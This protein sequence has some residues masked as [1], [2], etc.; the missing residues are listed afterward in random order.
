MK[1]ILKISF[2]RK[3]L[4]YLGIFIAIVIALNYFILPWYVNSPETHVP[5]VLGMLETQAVK[6]LQDN[7]FNPMISDTTFN[8]KYPVG[9]VIL[10]KP[11]PDKVVKVGRRVYL[12]ISGGE[13]VIKV[14]VLI[15]KSLRDAKFALER[16]GLNLG[17]VD[18]VT[19]NNPRDMIFDQ[20][21]AE[22]TQLK[23]GDDV[24]VSL[25]IGEGVGVIL[26][27]DLIGKSLTEAEKILA[28]NQLK[29]GK[30]NYQPSFSL[31]PNTVLDQYPS[32]GNKVN[33]GDA[34]DLFITKSAEP[35]SDSRGE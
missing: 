24:G 27:P 9:T 32:K 29:I 11:E 12:Y 22:G 35:N 20:Q 6:T 21:Y 2:V 34:I 28:D 8:E 16:L 10:Q 7:G 26:V 19:S 31:L 5:K 30:I 33:Q 3:L 1:N 25:S 4:I 15:G 17:K 14:P 18:S 13:P 23:K